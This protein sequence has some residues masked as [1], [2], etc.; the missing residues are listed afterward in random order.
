MNKKEMF[1][2]LVELESKMRAKANKYERGYVTANVYCAMTIDEEELPDDTG[3]EEILKA[4][5]EYVK[6]NNG[7]DKD[8]PEFFKE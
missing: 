1:I 4:A 7:E 2:K 6:W 3:N 8:K 5:K